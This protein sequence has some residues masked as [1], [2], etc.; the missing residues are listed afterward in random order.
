ME[1]RTGKLFILSGPS[2]SGKTTLLRHLLRAKGLRGKLIKSVSLTTRAKRSAERQGRDYFFISKEE[3]GRR[4]R[5]QK[6]LE[7]TRYLGYYYATPKETVENY[8]KRGKHIGMC[9]D[10]KG[11]L[12]IKRL[13]PGNAVTIFILPPSIKALKERIA[14]RCHKTKQEEIAKRLE[15]AREELAGQVKYDY[16]VVN[17]NLTESTEELTG[18]MLREM[19]S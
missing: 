13:Y 4:Q 1:K 17:K 9:L 15:L 11:A 2:G 18:I 3:F 10:L 19:H 16:C 8:L 14:K 7:W 5:A 12:R 6:I